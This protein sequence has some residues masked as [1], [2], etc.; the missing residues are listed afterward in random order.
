MRVSMICP[1]L[2]GPGRE[3]LR[4]LGNEDTELKV[5]KYLLGV[6]IQNNS[7]GDFPGGPVVETPR[8]PCKDTVDIGSVPGWGI[9]IPRAVWC[10]QKNKLK[11]MKFNKSLFRSRS[12]A[13]SLLLQ[14]RASY[15]NCPL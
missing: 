6:L 12:F 3:T 2:L 8:L 11:I 14:A 15:Q 10:G 5:T 13:L 4:T 7:Q 1:F 9:D